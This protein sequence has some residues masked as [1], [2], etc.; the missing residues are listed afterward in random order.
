MLAIGDGESAL[1][2]RV[3][4]GL[5]MLAIRFGEKCHVPA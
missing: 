1:S 2:P 4:L 5:A 3:L